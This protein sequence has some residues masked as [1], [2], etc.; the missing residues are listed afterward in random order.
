MKGKVADLQPHPLNA[1]IYNAIQ[2]AE[3]DDLKASIAKEGLITPITIT[4]E[5]I[6][7]SG[8]RRHQA[9]VALKWEEVEVD[10]KEPADEERFIIEANRYRRKTVSE[11]MKEAEKL[12]EIETRNAA[13]RM[14]LGAPAGAAGRTREKVAKALGI[15][16]GYQ[17]DK[18]RKIWD[19]A[20][21]NPN[22][23][24]KIK[25]LDSGHGSVESIFKSLS[26]SGKERPG[27]S[28]FDLQVYSLWYFLQPDPGLGMP[29]PGRIAG[30]VVQN[31]LWYYTM[32]GDLVIDPF[33]GGGITPD[34]CE[35]MDRRCLALDIAPVREDVQQWDITQGFPEGWSLPGKVI[36]CADA[37]L[38]FAD[39][40]YWNMLDEDYQE[41]SPETVSG[42]SLNGFR[43]FLFKFCADAFATM[44]S[45]G[46]LALIIMPQ[47][48][49]LPE[50]IPFMDW[51][52]E[53]R[54]AMDEAGFIPYRRITNR[55][56]TSIW[57]A[58]QVN[59]AKESKELLQVTGDILIGRKV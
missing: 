40:P 53:A 19:E 36:N 44:R 33:A 21:T 47:T 43:E 34:A 13:D 2:P 29:H 42:L 59:Q 37:Q 58:H 7:L 49:K 6:I 9:V 52:F 17:L 23:A 11:I 26:N 31:L 35:L 50:G 38:I 20:K 25:A 41:L 30:Q 27:L 48:Y 12:L 14:A 5:N 8:H 15:G 18:L 45:G 16:S 51:P 54:F 57:N 56:P 55:W 32:P 39:P 28:G 24:E 3:L 46:Y 10:V 4:K 22:I 1:K